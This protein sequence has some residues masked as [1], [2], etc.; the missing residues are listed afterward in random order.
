MMLIGK[1]SDAQAVCL[2]TLD[3]APPIDVHRDVGLSDSVERRIEVAMSS[4]DLSAIVRF[5]LGE[6]VINGNHIATLQVRCDVVDALK[7][8]LIENRLVNIDRKS[9]RLNSSHQIISY[10]VFCLK[11]K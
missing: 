10:A 1:A 11:K 8:S 5:L 6:T 4:A 7:C 3:D 9:T 2:R